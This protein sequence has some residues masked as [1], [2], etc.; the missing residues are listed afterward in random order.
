MRPTEI[1]KEEH[2]N[3]ERMLNVLERAVVNLQRGDHVSPEVFRE[4]LH[5]IR[6][7]TDGCHHRK[8]ETLLFPMM[9]QKGFQ[10][11]SGPIGVML[12]EHDL[13]R[14]EI[15][16]IANALQK[17][18]EGGG[19]GK[20]DLILHALNFISL[21]REHI[22]KEDKIL[23]VMA[24]NHFS[25]DDQSVLSEGFAA[26]DTGTPSCGMKADLLGILEKLELQQKAPSS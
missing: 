12:H 26:A 9:V 22:Q 3:I 20:K 21:L 25:D 16:A 14:T 17:Y 19:E 13:G 24:D 5:F 6:M 2:R 8:E 11:D 23:F 18:S 15:G 7:Y 1:L 4:I 10:R